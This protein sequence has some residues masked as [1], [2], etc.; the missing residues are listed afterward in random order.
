LKSARGDLKLHQ[1]AGILFYIY[2][3]SVYPKISNIVIYIHG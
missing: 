1:K 3:S 2:R